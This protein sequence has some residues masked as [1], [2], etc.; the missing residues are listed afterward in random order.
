MTGKYDT[1]V[2][3]LWDALSQVY[4]ADEAEAPITV[5][6]N[7]CYADSDAALVPT[8]LGEA[9]TVLM[10]GGKGTVPDPSVHRIVRYLATSL[11][12]SKESFVA[13]LTAREML[14]TCLASGFGRT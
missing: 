13:Q 5:L 3:A 1:H 2:K 9:A 4:P 12:D 7:S 11:Q 10:P 8:A 14:K 6:L